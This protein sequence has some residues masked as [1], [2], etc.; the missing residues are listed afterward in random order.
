MTSLLITVGN[1]YVDNNI[2]GVH[3]DGEFRL[4]PGKD[5]FADRGERVL[6]GSAVNAALQ[7]KRLG[8][9]VGFIGK[10]GSDEGAEEINVLLKASGILPDL[11][12]RDKGQTTSMAVN[13]VHTGGEFIGMHH[14]NASKTLSIDDIDL[15]NSLFER[16]NAIYFGGTAKQPLLF[17]ECAK[18]FEKLKDRNIKV[19][20]DPNRFAAHEALIDSTLLLDQLKF[21]EGYFPN[22]EELLQAMGVDEIDDAIERAIGTGVAF[23]ALKLGA[24]GCRIKTINDDFHIE[25]KSIKPMTTVGAGDCFNATFMASYLEGRS[26]KESAELAT[27]AA[28]IKVGSNLWPTLEKINYSLQR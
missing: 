2:F 26:L 14:G 24:K 17:K 27:A 5:Y 15:G 8:L 4:E 25:G 1:I 12:I 11:I 7:A 13:L 6:G 9:E 18:L 22:E 3:T 28:A 21:V 16:C 19:F 10:T 20:Y 23:V